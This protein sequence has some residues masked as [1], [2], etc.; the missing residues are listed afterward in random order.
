MV[1]EALTGAARAWA[2]KV[3]RLA[4]RFFPVLPA[5]LCAAIS[6]P[7]AA[8]AAWAD[9]PVT[10]EGL[11]Q[12]TNRAVLDLLPD[13]EAPTS[14][15]DAER[16]A[17]EAAARALAWLR[18]EGYYG[19]TVTSEASDEPPAARLIIEPG[20]RFLFDAPRIVY[21]GAPP[22]EGAA[23]AAALAIDGLNADAPARAAAVLEAES[24]ALAALH[25]AGYADA[26]VLNRRVVVDHASSQVATEFRF[27][28]GAMSSCCR[29]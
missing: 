21:E 26:A 19:A 13:R 24:D 8:P 27:N 7:A 3:L 28:A 23:S 25:Q 22:D 12:D 10:I 1:D 5:A 4:M 2:A 6:L 20:P 9:T 18:S 14:L 17:E 11:D 29:A 15:F 16:I